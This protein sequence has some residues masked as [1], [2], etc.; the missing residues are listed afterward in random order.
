MSN[1]NIQNKVGKLRFLIDEMTQQQLEDEVGVTKQTV[2][3]SKVRNIS[4]H[5]NYRLELRKYLM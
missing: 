3:Q 1:D 2:A 4:Q 5:W